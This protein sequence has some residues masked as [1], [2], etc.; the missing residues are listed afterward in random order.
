MDKK[1]RKR[2]NDAIYRLRKIGF[3]ISKEAA[4]EVRKTI[5]DASSYEKIEKFVTNRSD[6]T[7]SSRGGKGAEVSGKT[8]YKTLKAVRRRNEQRTRFQKGG[9]RY[10]NI[11]KARLESVG[12]WS[13]DFKDIKE[14]KAKQ[15]L[16]FRKYRKNISVNPAIAEDRKR[17]QAV[18]NLRKAM[19]V[20][21]Q[22]SPRLK[23]LIMQKIKQ[24][25]A[26]GLGEWFKKLDKGVE[27]AIFEYPIDSGILTMAGINVNAY[28][29][30]ILA[31]LDIDVDKVA[32]RDKGAM[33]N[34][35]LRDYIDNVIAKGGQ[36]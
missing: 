31:A 25:T 14:A 34:D 28:I 11:P 27:R 35:T 13:K 32:A 5:K 24:K 3:N 21:L 15:E 4:A 20:L 16:I 12:R 18:A 33:K 1:D 26:K 36:L 10:V 17:T 19:N 29:Y 7:F 23:Q 6:V 8:A 22:N 9:K 2:I 30:D